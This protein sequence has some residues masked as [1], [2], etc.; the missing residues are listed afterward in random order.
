[1]SGSF[2]Y[3]QSYSNST[4]NTYR[5]N[6]NNTNNNRNYHNQSAFLDPDSSAQ[7]Q[8]QQQQQQNF[9]RRPQASPA[10]SISSTTGST[11]APGQH[12]HSR[13]TSLH[14]SP[15]IQTLNSLPGQSS[16]SSNNNTA[17]H[18][19]QMSSGYPNQMLNPATSAAHGP[20]ST[21]PFYPIDPH[22]P[23]NTSNRYGGGGSGHHAHRHSAGSGL[24][25]VSPHMG[26]MG[27]YDSMYAAAAAA[28]NN[29]PP[30]STNNNALP[31]AVN[32]L[33]SLL[34][35]ADVGAGSEQAS[36]GLLPPPSAPGPGGLRHSGM[37]GLDGMSAANYMQ[38]G[39]AMG[40]GGASGP[41]VVPLSSGLPGMG[42]N[43]GPLHH[44]GSAMGLNHQ[45]HHQHHQQHQHPHQQAMTQL[46]PPIPNSASSAATA[47]PPS[48]NSKASSRMP[49]PYRPSDEASAQV[50][51]AAAASGVETA[52]PQ[53]LQH[54]TYIGHI[55]TAID[56][57][58]LLT[59]CD[60]TL[61]TL[62]KTPPANPESELAEDGLPRPRRV[63]RRLL[64]GER[65]SLI[66]SGSIFVW[67]EK[68]AGMRRWTDGR[69]WSASRV[70]GCFLTYR[71]LEGK[72]KTPAQAALIAAQTGKPNT[73]GTSNTY[74]IDGLIKQ[75]F[76]ITT[77]SGR[78][79][80]IISYFTKRDVRESR[81]RK[82][83][84]DPHFRRALSASAAVFGTGAATA[85]A[86]PPL[87]ASKKAKTTT[88][89]K[90]KGASN[91]AGG[92]SADFEGG[93]IQWADTIDENE[94]QDPTS[95]SGTDDGTEGQDA[96]DQNRSGDDEGGAAGGG[97]GGGGS[98][99]KK[100]SSSGG[101]AGQKRKRTAGDGGGSAGDQH[102]NYNGHGTS[103]RAAG[104]YEPQQQQQQQQQPYPYG[105]PNGSAL[106]PPAPF[107]PYAKRHPNQNGG[108]GA[109]QQQQQQHPNGSA[110]GA[111]SR[112]GSGSS[113]SGS[114]YGLSAPEGTSYS[115]NE[116]YPSTTGNGNENN[117]RS[118]Y[119]PSSGGVGQMM[120]GFP[121]NFGEQQ[122]QQQM[123][124]TTTGTQSVGSML[125]AGAAAKKQAAAAGTG[126]NGYGAGNRTT[127]PSLNTLNGMGGSSASA[128][129]SGGPR[130][131]AGGGSTSS[132]SGSG[133]GA[134]STLSSHPP[135]GSHSHYGGGKFLDPQMSSSLS[136]SGDHRP[137][138]KRRL[139]DG[140]ASCN[141]PPASRG[142]YHNH[143]HPTNSR[144]LP[145]LHRPSL[146][147]RKRSSSSGE[148]AAPGRLPTLKSLRGRRGYSPE[149]G[150]RSVSDGDAAAHHQG[151]SGGEDDD[152]LRLAPL[153]SGWSGPTHRSSS[154]PA[155]ARGGYLQRTESSVRDDNDNTKKSLSQGGGGG[156]VAISRSQSRAEQIS[157][158]GALL[159]LKSASASA[160]Q[161]RTSEGGDSDGAG[162]SLR[163]REVAGSPVRRHLR[164]EEEEDGGGFLRRRSEGPRGMDS[165]LSA[166]NKSPTSNVL[167]TPQTSTLPVRSFSTLS[168]NS[169]QSSSS[170]SSRSQERS[171]SSV[172]RSA[173]SSSGSG[174]TA[175]STPMPATPADGVPLSGNPA[176]Q[177]HR[178]DVDPQQKSKKEA[179]MMMMGG[180]AK[181]KTA[182]AGSMVGDSNEDDGAA[183][184]YPVY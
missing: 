86:L 1:M 13:Q 154:G 101:G 157:A 184:R 125:R 103:N 143:N 78:K 92:S 135:G 89:G 6:N 124:T 94:Y 99:Q 82:I 47:A 177:Q 91:A 37:V 106:S 158:V 83:H 130:G 179:S 168:S 119:N 38:G 15:Y 95:R 75:S 137:P 9:S 23:N 66:H 159:S 21:M 105:V 142:E 100:D 34:N 17:E 60:H 65:A 108:Y 73:G 68:E 144:S 150:A 136:R 11:V 76:S 131:L 139:A 80:H 45:L 8:Q 56:A 114:V 7:Q 72:K 14:Q 126:A 123:T 64:D 167:S 84:E 12:A 98:A 48:S 70:S 104:G 36:N 107:D 102:G 30:Q 134:S 149:G 77:L 57:I 120:Q 44:P 161:S 121:R 93:V 71:E 52:D 4:P 112:S 59:A 49:A 85:A 58:L 145:P 109:Q 19:P 170:S 39:M 155:A 54:P 156:G 35:A 28:G 20:T 116:A 140:R 51:A 81:L 176:L 178:L 46:P 128:N 88:N 97:G 90:G 152:D 166:D 22:G 62:G 111:N 117:W 2:Y 42:M 173:T 115:N 110:Y 63:T 174:Y 122:Q 25:T 175:D 32:N 169:N 16:S 138:L 163:E 180:E 148:L 113:L 18:S 164:D 61:A 127:L 96:M 151:R 26:G 55:K 10:P 31:P 24:S 50:V 181:V 87:P 129:G 43:G 53:A 160:S 183:R 67:D 41:S 29:G 40:T 171:D 147:R 172:P 3:N 133:N 27:M 33:N 74:K 69:C 5:N 165:L 132:S 182:A 153:S 146:G 118:T 162:S 141:S 79:M